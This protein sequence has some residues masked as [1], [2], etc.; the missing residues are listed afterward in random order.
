MITAAA[1][2]KHLLSQWA[3]RMETEKRVKERNQIDQSSKWS[4]M[5]GTSTS[6]WLSESLNIFIILIGNRKLNGKLS[7]V[8]ERHTSFA[9]ERWILDVDETN[10]ISIKSRKHCKPLNYRY[11]FMCFYCSMCNKFSC[12]IILNYSNGCLNNTISWRCTTC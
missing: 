9:L 10:Y 8:P 6:S 12:I 2:E 11:Y 7:C 4:D 3:G 1:A 5:K